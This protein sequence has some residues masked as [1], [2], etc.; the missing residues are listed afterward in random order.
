MYHFGNG[1]GCAYVGAEGLWK[2]P[3]NFAANL[4]CSKNKGLK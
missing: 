3:L 1:E 4:N 2:I